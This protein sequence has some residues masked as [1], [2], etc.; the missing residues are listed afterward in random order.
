MKN[1]TTR[2]L[3]SALA[4][5]F[6]MGILGPYQYAGLSAAV[7]V[8]LLAGVSLEP[9]FAV[10]SVVDYLLAGL[11]LPIYP[12]GGRGTG[13]LLGERG[14]FLLALVLCALVISA[15]IKGLRKRPKISSLIGLGVAFLLYFGMGILWYVVKTESSLIAVLT[16]GWGGTCLLFLLDCILAYV[17]AGPLKKALR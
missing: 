15:L 1:K 11:W 6:A 7:M 16:S 2:A 4:F 3:C 13:Y 17:A 14:G 12:A 10:L 9:L 5:A 8:V